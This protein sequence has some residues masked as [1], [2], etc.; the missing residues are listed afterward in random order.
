MTFDPHKLADQIAAGNRR[1]LARAITLIEST[2]PDHQRQADALLIALMPRTGR[3]LRIGITGAPGVGKSTFIEAIGETVIAAGHRLAVLA[4]DPSSSLSGGSILGDKTRM[5][6]LTQRD[7]AFIRPS[8]SGGALGGLNRRTFETLLLCEAAGFDVVIVETVGVGQ[9]ETR[10]RDIADLFLLLLSP[11][12]GDEL[13]GLK[14]GIV[15]LA[16]IMI[17][18]KAEG[19]RAAEARQTAADYASALKLLRPRSDGW[20]VPVLTCA[21]LHKQDIAPVWQTIVAF[22]ERL[23]SADGLAALR[24]RQAKSWMWDEIGDRL[25]ARFH[26]DPATARL[27]REL[28]AE[29]IAGRLPAPVASERLL[30]AF[31]HQQRQEK[32]SS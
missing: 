9:S 31:F 25:L 3:S 4:V 30:D 17:V 27:T 16:D 2:R 7:E 28:E 19:E 21:A 12:G 6:S 26:A 24:G 13:Q 32:E 22:R 23:A 1:A 15:E 10:V 5:E 20:Q 8:P 29:V 14:R 11:G 18:N